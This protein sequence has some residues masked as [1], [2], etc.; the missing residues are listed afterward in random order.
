M[1]MRYKGAV[2]SATPPTTSTTTATG[3]WTL[4]QQMQAQGAGTWPV[5]PLAWIGTLSGP[6][7][8]KGNAITFDASSNVY[9]GGYNNLKFETAKYNTS[10]V[11]QWQRTLNIGNSNP[12]YGVTGIAVDSSSNV[13]V[14]GVNPSYAQ[15]AKYDS[16]GAIQWQRRL[17]PGMSTNVFSLSID[18]S[19]NIYIVGTSGVLGTGQD[20]QLQKYNSSGT[21]QWQKTLYGSNQ[22]FGTGGAV[23]SSGN[24]YL[25]GYDYSSGLGSPYFVVAKYNTSGTIQWQRRIGSGT[26]TT[27]GWGIAADASG[28]LYATGYVDNVASST[29]VFLTV[30]YN[31]SGAIQWQR[32][33]GNNT[34]NLYAYGAAVDSSG[35]VYITGKALLGG[36]T[37]YL[38]I[39]KYNSSG[40]IQWQRVLYS[41]SVGDEGLGVSV[42]TFGNMYIIGGASTTSGTAKFLLA[43]LPSDGSLTGTYTVGGVSF[44][45]AASSYT[46]AASSFSEAA[47]SLTDT[48]S[49]FTDSATS[50]TDSAS[51]LT[52]SVTTL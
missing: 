47:S 35:N 8:G 30:K 32:T 28:N 16:S 20:I 33:L 25:T 52:S 48:T 19:S 9:V 14:A 18:T 3:V 49:T 22:Q 23:D 42:D 1:S 7:A 11:I 5:R 46:D 21:I 27:A 37:S 4:V 45:Y 12:D 13:Y 43:K 39:A 36:S 31:S 41:D 17:G 38:I 40:V 24:L 50:F 26:N 15:I 10:G 2:I 51:T 44:T 29:F 6:N 34:L